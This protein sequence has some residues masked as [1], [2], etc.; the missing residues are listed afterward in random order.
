[1]IAEAAKCG[2]LFNH[3]GLAAI[4]VRLLPHS[5]DADP[6]LESKS[7]D[8]G[9]TLEDHS[10]SSKDGGAREGQVTLVM[11]GEANGAEIYDATMN[12]NGRSEDDK[13]RGTSRIDGPDQEYDG[14]PRYAA[15]VVAE[16]HNTLPS[17]SIWWILEVLPFDITIFDHVSGMMKDVFT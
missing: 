5:S 11:D 1:M 2:V 12:S 3:K 7:R 9:E 13:N 16:L 17:G 8:G 6:R 15:D 14:H 4:G 10:D